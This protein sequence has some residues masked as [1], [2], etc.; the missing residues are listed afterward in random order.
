MQL[1]VLLPPIFGYDED[2]TDPVIHMPDEITVRIAPEP[3]MP[4]VDATAYGAPKYVKSF[5]D[6]IGQEA[7]KRELGVYIDE[8]IQDGEP[9]PHT[10]LASS[11]PGIGKG[12]DVDTMLLTPLG[13]RRIGDL[14]L[15]NQVIGSNGHATTVTGLYERGTLPLYRVTFSDGS[16]VRC[17]GEH[18]WTVQTPSMRNRAKWTTADTAT[19]MSGPLTDVLGRARYYIPMAAQVEHHQ[20]Q[21]AKLPVEPYLTGV[22]LGNADFAKGVISLNVADRDIADRIVARLRSWW[23]RGDPATLLSEYPTTTGLRFRPRGANGMLRQIGQENIASKDKFIPAAYLVAP[24][25]HRRELLAGLMDTDGGVRTGRGSAQFH[26]T[27]PSLANGVQN[28]VESLGGTAR[29][30]MLKRGEIRVDINILENPF[31]SQRKSAL[32]KPPSRKPSRSIVSIV[33]DGEGEVRCIRVDAMDSLYVTERYIV[34]HNTTL[35]ELIAQELQVRYV[36]LVP[37]FSAQALYQ[38]ALSMHD[39]EI[40]FIDEAHKLADQGPRAAENLYHMMEEGVLYLE[41]GPHRL[42]RFTVMGATTDADKL[43][44]PI[45]DRFMIKPYFQP[46]NIRELELITENFAGFYSIDLDLDVI[47]GIARACRGTPRVARELVVGARALGKSLHRPCTLA[48]LLEFKQVEPNGL[49]R[50]HIAYLVAMIN[51]FGNRDRD[52][53][54]S[55]VAGEATLMSMLRENK[56][57]LSRLER[58]LIERGLL[59]RTPRGRRLTDTGVQ[60]ALRYKVQEEA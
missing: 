56:T 9:F 2:R 51:H 41:D 47:M 42:A 48:E 60:T 46:Y 15:G 8:A 55:Y 36:K 29:V 17:D 6:F 37:P 39:C 49:T 45:L 34:T 16:S 50:Q 35:A 26:T 58:Y 13:W 43:P 25:E 19:L 12:H 57:G 24:L 10:L 53:K 20:I 38:A 1:G 4:F 21:A 7:M 18:L 5:D 59:D 23:K 30:R 33:P 44:E 52:G 14:E 31:R 40:L 3:Q 27:S 22:M 28:L 54:I 11:M 32:W